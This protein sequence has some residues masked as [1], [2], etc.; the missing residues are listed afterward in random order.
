MTNRD[1]DVHGSVGAAELEQLIAD[2][3]GPPL[4]ALCDRL[5]LRD[6]AW[7]QRVSFRNALTHS[8]AARRS[9]QPSDRWK[10][11]L[12]PWREIFGETRRMAERAAKSE[13]QPG[14]RVR[15]REEGGASISVPDAR[16]LGKEG[17]IQHGTG[18]QGGPPTFYFVEFETGP[19]LDKVMA[20][21]ADWLGPPQREQQQD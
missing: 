15:V 17:T 11:E 7:R 18:N 1:D 4:S 16:W 21:S 10:T 14:Q 20:I 19:F 5:S 2:S 6:S 9:A 13:F 8:V 12:K 3:I